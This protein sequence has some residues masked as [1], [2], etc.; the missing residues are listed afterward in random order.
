MLGIDTNQ[1]M[2]V[3]YTK[4]HAKCGRLSIDYDSYKYKIKQ[5]DKLL[6]VFNSGKLS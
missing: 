6:W 2:C 4:E 1:K 3:Y 5:F